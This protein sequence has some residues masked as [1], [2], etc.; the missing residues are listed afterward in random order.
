MTEQII[1]NVVSE[2][3]IAQQDLATG[4]VCILRI[5]QVV[6]RPGGRSVRRVDNVRVEMVDEA[7]VVCVEGNSWADVVEERVIEIGKI[8]AV[9]RAKGWESLQVRREICPCGNAL[10]NAEVQER[11]SCDDENNVAQNGCQT[12]VLRVDVVLG[13][14]VV[15]AAIWLASSNVVWVECGEALHISNGI[16]VIREP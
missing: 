12:F 2:R 14:C 11:T 4:E 8:R 15:W 16:W 5:A 1:V 9:K 6:L 7:D 10:A 13:T 3:I